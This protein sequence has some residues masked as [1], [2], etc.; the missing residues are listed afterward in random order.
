MK[1]RAL[2][3][4]AALA[5]CALPLYSADTNS[6]LAAAAE[7]KL[8]EIQRNGS[9]AHPKPLR[10]EFSE[11]EINAYFAA[12]K[13]H[14]PAGVES[15][16][17]QSEPGVVTATTKV[18]FDKVKAGRTSY[19]PLLEIFTGVHR[20]VVVARARGAGGMG[21]AQI[22]TVSLDGIEI[23]RFVLQL[24]VEKYVQPKYPGLGLDSKFPLPD[25]IDTAI[26]GAHELTVT[27]K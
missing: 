11:D 4:L 2:L 22:D 8:H 12:G 19:N 7:R 1:A 3:L 25:R 21:Y 6:R 27:Q 17:F 16:R 18:D 10:T 20:V 23:P 15:V 9:T 26:V 13:V 24:F 14:L 5:L